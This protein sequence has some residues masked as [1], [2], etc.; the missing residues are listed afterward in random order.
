MKV[1]RAVPCPPPPPKG[2]TCPHAG[3]FTHFQSRPDRNRQRKVGLAVPCQ[4][5]TANRDFPTRTACVTWKMHPAVS[6]PG[7]HQAVATNEL[8]SRLRC[9]QTRCPNIAAITSAQLLRV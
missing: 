1:G 4:P 7:S 5:L 9:E 3:R 6:C 8:G 2:K